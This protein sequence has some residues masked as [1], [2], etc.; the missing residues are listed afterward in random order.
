M[1]IGLTANIV[2]LNYNLYKCYEMPL[3]WILRYKINKIQK[4][5][6]GAA[7]TIATFGLL[8]INPNKGPTI[9]LGK[10]IKDK[11]YSQR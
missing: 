3:L 7:V 11:L 6:A 4:V 2:E 1:L 8:L 9:E 5:L 10:K